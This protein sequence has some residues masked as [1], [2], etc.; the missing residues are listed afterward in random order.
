[1]HIHEAAKKAKEL[2]SFITRPELLSSGIKIKP[3]DEPECCMIFKN[4]KPS[5]NR[6]NPK[7]VDLTAQDWAVT[8]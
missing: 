6:W 8:N 4:N 5:A 1:M 3:T 7:A 2:N